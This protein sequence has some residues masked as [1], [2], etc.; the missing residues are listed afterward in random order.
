MMKRILLFLAVNV[1]VI[2]TIGIVTSVLG[3]RPYITQYGIDFQALLAFSAVV[4][5][6]GAF[7]S[8]ALSRVMAKW[9][10]GVQVLDPQAHLSNDARE[11]VV[12]VHR[13]AKQAGL[14][15]MPQVGVYESEEVNAFATGPTKNRSLVAVSSGLLA[16]MDQQAVE[17]V[18]AHEIS[19]V[20][21]GDMVTMTLIQGVINTFVVFLSRVAAYVVTMFFRRDEDEGGFPYL[22]NM[23]AVIVFDILFSILGSI[24]VM[25]FSRIREFRADAGGARLAGRERMVHALESLKKSVELV[26]TQQTAL[27]TLKIS[28][29]AKGWMKLFAS[30]P[31]LD[32]RI[33]RL[34]AGA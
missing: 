5:F 25:Y 2:V 10:M 26:D 33:A 7:I 34:K 31:D 30:H 12:Q 22:V 11:L 8:L 18:L 1:L 15:A 17:G 4:G 13:L 21:N 14:S 28:G 23:I 16:R 3:I 9:M 24:V 27:A 6:S 20:A 29:G 32:E 19:H